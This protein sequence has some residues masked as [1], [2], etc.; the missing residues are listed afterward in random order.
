MSMK[1]KL[2]AARAVAASWLPDALMI[3]G[4]GGVSCGAGLVYLPV[5][6]IVAGL[7][8]LA[9]GWMLARGAK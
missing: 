1:D 8:A 3:A 6:W 7:F 2:Q 5:G 9:A 4:A